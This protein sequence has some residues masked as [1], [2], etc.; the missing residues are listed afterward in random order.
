M[1][2]IML[3]VFIVILSF[4]NV[5]RAEMEIEMVNVLDVPV[6]TE[7]TTHTTK[8]AIQESLDEVEKFVRIYVKEEERAEAYVVLSYICIASMK[9]AV[10]AALAQKMS[11]DKF[12]VGPATWDC[13]HQIAEEK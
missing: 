4:A 11:G 7:T 9:H 5:S 6:S 10:V 8:E 13:V 2:K 1:N 3:F 12:E